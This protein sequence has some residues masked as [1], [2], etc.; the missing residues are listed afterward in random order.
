M[1]WLFCRCFFVALC[2]SVDGSFVSFA[3]DCLRVAC[4]SF[5]CCFL[6]AFVV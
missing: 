5:V 1:I 2:L 6:S 4:L 3:F